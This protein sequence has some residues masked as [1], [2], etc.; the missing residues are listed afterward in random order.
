VAV[1]NGIEFDAEAGF[2]VDAGLGVSNTQRGMML[3][4]QIL[5]NSFSLTYYLG[6]RNLDAEACLSLVLASLAFHISIFALRHC[7]F[8][9]EQR[10]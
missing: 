6:R 3:L 1:L 10:K 8:R 2:G 7:G 5:C 4:L 9:L